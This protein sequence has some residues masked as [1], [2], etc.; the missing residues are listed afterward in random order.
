MEAD[1]QALIAPFIDEVFYVTS[2][3]GEERPTSGGDVRY[4]NG[5]D[6][7][8]PSSL[9]NVPVYSVCNGT[10]VFVG[11]DEGGFG[12]YL[13]IKD[14]ETEIGFLYAHL[15]EIYV[16]EGWQVEIGE[17]IALEGTTGS[18]TGIHLH[19]AMQ[20]LS[21]GRSWN[22]NAYFTDYLNPADFMGIPN[23]EGISV[24]YDGI[25]KN[26][27]KERGFPWVLYARKFRNRRK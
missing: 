13:I 4:H 22:Y 5:I 15:H 12:N 26:R 8:T 3:F 16:L 9:G 17:E 21:G 10:V 11:Y 6:I 20:N 25:P 7:A 18:S 27:K 24:Y 2:E 14:N 19:L 23:V 1:Y